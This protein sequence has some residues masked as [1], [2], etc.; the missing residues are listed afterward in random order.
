MTRA[1]LKFLIVTYTPNWMSVARLVPRLTEQGVEVHVVCQQGALITLAEGLAGG[2][3][4]TPGLPLEVFGNTVYQEALRLRPDL[5]IPG[6]DRVVQL[7]HD[8]YGR[9]GESEDGAFVRALIERSLGDPAHYA[10]IERKSALVEMAARTGAAIP[11]SRVAVTAEEALDFAGGLGYPVLLKPDH[12]VGGMGITLCDGPERLRQAFGLAQAQPLGVRREVPGLTVQRFVR[13]PTASVTLLAWQGRMLAGFS[14]LR[15]HPFPNAFGLASQLE[16]SPSPVM[17][18]RAARVVAS[19]GFS[20]LGSVQFVVDEQSGEPL[21]M[22]INARATPVANLGARLGVDLIGGL[23]AILRGEALPPDT[24]PRCRR[25][26]FFPN[27]VL[28]DP[29]SPDLRDP[30]VYHDVPHD[31]PRLLAHLTESL[32]L[33]EASSRRN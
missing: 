5:I 30:A 9:L 6:E 8:L 29:N 12:G 19:F 20:G 10:A 16:L 33:R 27:E 31:Q 15:R 17:L 18:E 13:G 32:R 25:V 4:L 1:P 3:V 21:V 24:E 7:L 22:E 2:V 23:C 11:E 14:W 28:R 26:A